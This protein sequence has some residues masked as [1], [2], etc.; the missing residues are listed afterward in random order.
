MLFLALYSIPFHASVEHMQRGSNLHVIVMNDPLIASLAAQTPA[1]D[2][3]NLFKESRYIHVLML[4]W[5]VA[6]IPRALPQ[7]GSYL[8][9]Q[10]VS[11][12]E[13]HV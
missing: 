9:H 7:N 10:L 2:S 4:S 1:N 5:P 6:Y 8:F 3:K 12:G 11:C 13:V